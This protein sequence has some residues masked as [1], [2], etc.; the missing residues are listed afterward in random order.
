MTPLY[1]ALILIVVGLVMAWLS[2]GVK[3]PLL[4][5]VVLWVG[6]VLVGIGLILLLTP[7]IV[8]INH[9]LQSMLAGH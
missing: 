5:T 2:G 6:I 7:V 3:Y 9:Q 4:V 8:W 1:L